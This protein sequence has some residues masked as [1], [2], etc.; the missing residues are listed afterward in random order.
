[1]GRQPWPQDLVVAWLASLRRCLL[2]L[3]PKPKERC[4]LFG[5][6]PRVAEA[7]LC[8]GWRGWPLGL[9]SVWGCGQRKGLGLQLGLPGLT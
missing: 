2:F 6:L 9:S 1:M 4:P 8:W 5:T 3:L 7:S